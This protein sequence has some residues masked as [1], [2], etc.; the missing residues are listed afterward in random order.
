MTHYPG[1]E[2]AMWKYRDAAGNPTYFKGMNRPE[3]VVLHI[4]QGHAST[5]RAWAAQGHYGAS[6]HY[7]VCIDGTVLQQLEHEDGGYHAGIASPPAPTPT[8]PLWRG[9][10]QNINTYTIGIEQEGFSGDGFPEAQRLASRD[11]CRWLASELGFPYDRDHF[12][13]HADIDLVNRPN[14]FGPPEYR[15][16][17]YRFMF[18]EESLTP[19]DVAR[20]DRLEKLLAANGIAKDPAAYVASGYDPALLTFGEEAVAYAAERGWSAFLGNGLNQADIAAHKAEQPGGVIAP[21]TK[22]TSE[23]IS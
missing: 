14:D 3:A 15:E 2:L 23:V 5:A 16:E 1:A 20:I 4:S 22:F 12:P 10:T 11:L 6:W 21:G 8:W 18:E 9:S 19:E 17:H 13:P 7:F